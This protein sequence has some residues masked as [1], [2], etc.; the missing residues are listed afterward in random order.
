MGVKTF[1]RSIIADNFKIG[2]VPFWT[3][4]IKFTGND[5]RW[6][7]IPLINLDN[8][9][10]SISPYSLG[11]IYM[12]RTTGTNNTGIFTFS[13]LKLYNTQN[14]GWNLNYLK[15]DDG[16]SMNY[17]LVYYNNGGIRYCGLLLKYAAKP[18]YYCFYGM[19][20]NVELLDNP[21][22]VYNSSASTVLNTEIYNS[23]SEVPV[24]N[25]CKNVMYVPPEIRNAGGYFSPLLYHTTPP[26]SLTATGRRGQLSFDNNY[27][28]MATD[29]N[30][31]V[32]TP[33]VR[34]KIEIRCKAGAFNCTA[35]SSSE[36]GYINPRWTYGG[37]NNHCSECKLHY[38]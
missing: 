37:N 17:S 33:I 34:N 9:N 30:T 7:I 25:S 31:W 12:N 38:N 8:T 1:S 3:R 23:I 14:V 22:E 35:S 27:I 5:N 36:T 28:Y 32:R 13:I 24:N 2:Y 26:T 18:N 20:S 16:D 19:M 4:P 29:T 6:T 10:P 15:A 11:S 21:I